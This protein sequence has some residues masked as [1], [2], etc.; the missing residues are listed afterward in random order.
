MSTEFSTSYD[1]LHYPPYSFPATHIGRLAAI[2]HL[3]SLSVVHPERARV[4]ELGCGIGANLSCMAQCLP[5]ASFVGVDLSSKQI[6]AGR[7][8]LKETG[9]SNVELHHCNAADLSPELGEFDYIIAHGLFSWVDDSTRASILD[10]IARHLSPHGVAYV[11]YNCLPG[12]RMRSAL[13]DMMQMHTIGIEDLR[14][15]VAQGKELLKFL[16]ECCPKDTPY[17]QYLAGELDLLNGSDD[18]YIAHEFFEAENKPFYFR[19]FVNQASTHGL[20]Y[21]AD[22]EVS[23][24]LLEN[25]PKKAADILKSLKLNF[26]AQ[27]QYMDFLRNRMFRNSLLFKT[28]TPIQRA[29]S[30]ER[31]EDLH[32]SSFLRMEKGSEEG[33]SACFVTLHGMSLTVSDALLAK[34]LADVSALGSRTVQCKKFLDDVVATSSEGANEAEIAALRGRIATLLIQSSFRKMLEFS[35]GDFLPPRKARQGFPEALPMAGWQD[36]NRHRVSA[37]RLQMI[38]PDPFVGRLISLSDGK[39]SFEEIVQTLIAMHGSGEFEITENK[40]PMRDAKRVPGIIRDLCGVAIQ[41]LQA[42]EIF[43]PTN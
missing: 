4:L 17:G 7:Q 10:L 37:A 39:R 12:W 5:S 38:D 8:M 41:R 40:L 9:I 36:R 33:Q 27:E 21:L 29:V 34:V 42:A 19:D 2:G 11:S 43:L 32:L 20:S 25:L 31:I 35:M 6:A 22:T 15:R 30:V 28:G 24:M 26:L 1:L 16:V 23:S 18:S 13:R 14:G 3:F